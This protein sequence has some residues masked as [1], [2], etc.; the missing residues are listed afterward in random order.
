MQPRRRDFSRS[1]QGLPQLAAH[2]STSQPV[3]QY[4]QQGFLPS[5]TAEG[6]YST[7]PQEYR[8]HGPLPSAANWQ[9]LTLPPH[10]KR[11]GTQRTVTDWQNTILPRDP[12]AALPHPHQRPATAASCPPTGF[13]PTCGHNHHHYHQSQPPDTSPQEHHCIGRQRSWKAAD[14]RQVCAE[15][16]DMS[17]ESAS[18][19]ASGTQHT[20][21]NAPHHDPRRDSGHANS[22]RNVC[23][24]PVRRADKLRPV[25]AEHMQDCSPRQVP[26]VHQ[27][28][29]AHPCSGT[30]G[31]QSQQASWQIQ[32]EFEH[33]RVHSCQPIRQQDCFT[34]E[35]LSVQYVSAAPATAGSYCH[36][37]SP[38]L[39]RFRQ[40]QQA[41]MGC[42]PVT[43]AAQEGLPAVGPWP[44]SYGSAHSPDLLQVHSEQSRVQ[45]PEGDIAAMEAVL[46]EYRA[47]RCQIAER[48]TQLEMV[49]RR[50]GDHHNLGWPEADAVREQSRCGN[51]PGHKQSSCSHDLRSAHGDD[52]G[53][54]KDMTNNLLQ[55]KAA[56]ARQRPAVEAVAKQLRSTLSLSRV[57]SQNAVRPS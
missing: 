54:P 17:C 6:L 37:G 35:T 51:Y 3:Q 13:T 30:A 16:R 56:A 43:D 20:H 52:T 28:A 18:A 14:L 41:V 29:L 38:H 44:Q 26:R 4:I 53:L 36:A 19:A 48:E 50:A 8:Q 21:T 5:T 2:L 49:Q 57:Q 22:I 15:V 24:D 9:N 34:P 23:F 32:P 7:L 31:M 46:R 10:D 39:S 33:Q 27:A 11:Q 12:S 45:L 55:L 42:E 1:S 47:L 40:H 25:T